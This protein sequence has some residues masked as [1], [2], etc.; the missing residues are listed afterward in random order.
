M[1]KMKHYNC[2][3]NTDFIDNIKKDTQ[4]HSYISKWNDGAS[5]YFELGSEKFVA[6]FV[7][8]HQE[9]NIG[10]HLRIFGDTETVDNLE[11]FLLSSGY[12]VYTD[13]YFDE[14][15]GAKAEILFSYKNCKIPFN[16]VIDRK[17]I[18]KIMADLLA[19]YYKLSR[20][21]KK[22][23]IWKIYYENCK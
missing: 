16:R 8:N 15:F 3:E 2:T 18:Y 9:I 12:V 10:V 13:K 19:N 11:N 22:S 1:I 4:N 21:Q 5:I 23:I 14:H 17:K 7:Y 6:S 20:S